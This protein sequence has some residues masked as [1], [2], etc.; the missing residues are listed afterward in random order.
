[1]NPFGAM[2]LGRANLGEAAQNW[3]D[4]VGSKLVGLQRGPT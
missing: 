3:V 2:G 1:M 4:S